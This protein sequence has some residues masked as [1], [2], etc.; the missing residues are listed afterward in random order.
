MNYKI[1]VR[2]IIMPLLFLVLSIATSGRVFA[3][4]PLAPTPVAP[5]DGANVAIPFTLSWSAVSDPAGIIGYNWEVSTSSNFTNVILQNSTNGGTQDTVSGLAGGT[6]FW[7]VQAVSGALVQGAWSQTRSFNVAGV[8]SGTPGTP[9]LEPTLA[10]S[11]FHPMEVIRFRWNAVPEAATYVLQFSKDSGFPVS[12]RNQ[13]DNIPNNTY[14][15]AIGDC[16]EGFYYARVYAVSANGIAG[17]PSNVISFSVFFNNPLPP[18]PTLLL[19]ANGTTL[20]LPITLSWTASPNPQPGG[21]DLQIARDSSFTNIEESI[22]QLNDPTRTVLSLTSGRKFWRVHSV[23]G[24]SSPSTAAVTA[25]SATGTFTVSSE[26]PRPISVSVINNPLYSGDTT[27]VQVQLSTAVPAGGAAVIMNSSNQSAAPVPATIQMPGN[28]GWTQ[29]QIRAGQVNLPTPVTLTATINGVTIA[30]Q[31]TVLPPSLKDLTITPQT[32]SGGSQTGGIVMLN[33][34]AA[35]GGAVVSLTSNSPAVIPPAQVIVPPGS[36]SVS[37]SIATNNVTTQTPVIITANWNGVTTQSQVTVMPGPIPTSLTLF[38]ATIIGGGAG[39]ADGTVTVASP[40]PFDQFLQVTSN[41]P[42]VL[43][44]LSQ[45]VV[46]PANTTR[47]SILLLPS[48]VSV[49]TIVTISVTGGG[50]TSSANLTV[51]PA[52][53]PIP[54][55]TLSSFSVSPTSVA[56]GSPATGTVTLPSAAPAGGTVVTLAS[57]LPGAASVPPSVTIPA[58][59]TS[60][61]FTVTT[62]PSAGTTVQLSARL[63]DSILFAPLGVNPPVQPPTPSAPTLLSP[64]NGATVALPATLDWNDT[65]NAASYTIQIDDSSSFTAPLVSEQSGVTAS[66]ITTGNLPVVP[67][68]WR[69]RAVNSAGIAGVWS[70]VRKFTPQSAPA[71]PTLSSVSLNP[72]SVV[73]GN[74]ST[75]TVTLTSIAPNGGAVVSLSSSNTTAAGVPASVTIPAGATGATFNLTTGSVT[76]STPVTISATFGGVARTATLTVTPSATADTVAIQVAQYANG[77]ELQVQA[78]SNNSG[79]VLKCYVTATNALIGTLRNDGGGRYSGKLPW[80]A[81]PQNITVRSSAGGTAFKVVT[82]K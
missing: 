34:Q 72:S 22:P 10:Y 33:G 17:V 47:G 32:I 50:V 63:G 66:Q 6:Y 38:P 43:P 60:A 36:P 21:Y 11:T 23:Q 39:S 52:G 64:A 8:G 51:N 62:F 3:V 49:Q 75:G 44:F 42:A 16:C 12:T 45:V 25:W 40:A 81:N 41:N 82:V 29:F 1:S 9:T 78:T 65:V 67:Y 54:P 13:F 74:A 69:V 58:G 55:A 15:F 79:A 5:A 77:G 59:A 46:I 14:G 68:W 57:N 61:S 31:F 35:A 20:T 19:P 56:G 37:F 71:A 76:A 70:A 48:A 30:G 26:A 73:G 53:T 80:S 4:V 27:W 2:S 18:P 7:H 28:I 24:D